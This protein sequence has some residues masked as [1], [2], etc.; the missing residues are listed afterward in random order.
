M[1]RKTTPSPGGHLT[2]GLTTLDGDQPDHVY[3]PQGLDGWILHQTVTGCGQLAGGAQ[4]LIRAGDWLLFPP[5]VAHDYRLA[6]RA[7]SWQHRWIYFWPEPTWFDWL[8]GREL[9]GG[10]RHLGNVPPA[11]DLRTALFSELVAIARG[12]RAGGP[13]L[14]RN[15]LEQLLIRCHLARPDHPGV[16]LDPRLQDLLSWLDLHHQKAL[17]LKDLA[18]ACGLSP[19]RLSHHFRQQMGVSPMKHLERVRLQRAAEHLLLGS[20]AIGAVAAQV[21]MPDQ[22]WFARTF[23]R[24]FGCSPRQFRSRG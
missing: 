17:S 9:P 23:R 24:H 18:D 8:E 4:R 19:S 6:E 3:R 2:A 11:E 21:G 22:T 14:A 1:S 10:V 20:S 16:R 12:E 13:A 7:E 5:G 15:L